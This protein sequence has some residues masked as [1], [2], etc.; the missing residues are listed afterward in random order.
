MGGRDDLRDLEE[1]RTRF[2]TKTP[3]ILENEY[4]DI[5]TYG[6]VSPGGHAGVVIRSDW[7]VLV[8]D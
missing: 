1:R 4:Q 6:G 8:H 3:M 2:P 5:K 7:K